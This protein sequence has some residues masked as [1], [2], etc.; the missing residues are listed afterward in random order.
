MN[1]LIRPER[2]ATCT[3]KILSPGARESIETIMKFLEENGISKEDITKAVKVVVAKAIDK[4]ITQEAVK[5]V[6]EEEAKAEEEET[7][8][9]TPEETSEE[10]SEEA[11]EEAPE[12]S[13]T[14]NE[15]I[16]YYC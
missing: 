16:G 4:K 3:V 10:T 15:Q 1:A 6:E 8:Q 14:D 7:S 11:P 5:E 13:N 9:E 2:G 12:Q